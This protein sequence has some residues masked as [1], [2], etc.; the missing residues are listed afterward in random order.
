[1]ILSFHTCFEAD[2][3]RICAGR[4]P[5]ED[6]ITAIKKAHAVILPQGCR[7]SLYVAAKKNCANVF[8]NYDMRFAY[9]GKLGQTK[10]FQELNI[11]HPKTKIFPDINSLNIDSH[12]DFPFVLKFDWGGEGDGVFFIN[13]KEDWE[14]A[15]KRIITFEKEGRHG[16]LIQEFIPEGNSS[17]RVVV[18]GGAFFS[19]FRVQKNKDCYYSNISKGGYIDFDYN[20]ALQD[21]CISLAQMFCS[22]TGINLAGFDFIFSSEFS[23]P[24][25]LEINYFFGRQGLG[26]GETFYKILNSEINNWI[27]TKI[28][29]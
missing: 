12:M 7:E 20:P 2:D 18:I 6:D 25:F 19:Y 22:K 13:S 16:F 14:L 8:P 29:V 11:N 15:F 10:L 3:N 9:K 26:G 24:F 27:K 23:P 5:N 4:D 21:Q 28:I 17:V 1:M